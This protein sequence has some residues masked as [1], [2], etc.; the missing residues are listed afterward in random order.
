MFF[1]MCICDN[2][3]NHARESHCL[4]KHIFCFRIIWFISLQGHSK[5]ES[6]PA[7]GFPHQLHPAS[8]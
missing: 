4:A 5:N 7:K 3:K 8:N 1:Y 2:S 6:L